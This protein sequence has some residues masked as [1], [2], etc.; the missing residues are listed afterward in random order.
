MKK[1]VIV[2]PGGLGSTIAA[3][4]AHKAV[5]AVSIAGRPGAHIENIRQNG[6]R[7]CG[8]EECTVR[9]EATD[10]PSSIQDCDF[11]IFLIKAPDTAAALESTKHII[12]RDAVVS[13]QNGVIK[14]DLL[15]DTF[16]QDK[17]IGGLAVAAGERIE[18][19]VA[20]W[21][22]DG[23]TQ[24]GELDGTP[25][26]RVESLV[27]LFRQAGFNTEASDAVL[28]S[29]WTKMVAWVPLGL[30]ACLAH[31]NNAATLSNQHLVPV[32]VSMVREFSPLAAARGVPLTNIGPYHV[33]TWC[34]GSV[35]EAAAVV[36]QS[37]LASSQSMHSGLQDI[38]KGQPTEFSACVGPMLQEARDHYSL[39]MPAVEVMYATLMALEASLQSA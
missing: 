11:L 25:S 15:I 5:C 2:G 8:L 38:L 35:E 28:S 6:L 22:Y 36:M 9:L 24:F 23:I 14:D 21:T 37:P 3:L 39:S 27:D 30:I 7:L 4:M 16:G 34:R 17:V 32:Y 10:D 31:T 1:V 29:T 12:V 13:L 20:R 33:E 18:P 19:G 26:E